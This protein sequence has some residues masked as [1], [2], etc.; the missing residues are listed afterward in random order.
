[1]DS[2]KVT[3][4]ALNDTFRRS[5]QGGSINMTA[6]IAALTENVRSVILRRVMSFNAFDADNDPNEEHDFGA[7]EEHGHK[8]FWK[9]DYYTTDMSAGSEH[10]EDPAQ[11]ARVLTVMLAEEY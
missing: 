3:I 4:R 7:F 8:V 1:M 9:I 11:T 2:K 5:F 6:G 10:P